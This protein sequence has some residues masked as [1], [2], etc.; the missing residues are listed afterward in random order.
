MNIEKKIQ[1]LHSL[2]WNRNPA[3]R[4]PRW[5]FEVS[6][7]SQAFSWLSI[8]GSQHS[9]FLDA[10]WLRLNTVD[11]DSQ[12]LCVQRNFWG[13]VGSVERAGCIGYF[14]GWWHDLFWGILCLCMERERW[15]VLHFIYHQKCQSA[16]WLYRGYEQSC[17][18]DTL[19][20]GHAE[21][22][23]QKTKGHVSILAK[24]H[25]VI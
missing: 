20:H 6:S 23:T 3:L 11:R 24:S 9:A 17:Q 7:C 13:R 5:I 22:G 12:C 21:S 19:N 1:I 2:G 25:S 15:T 8:H 16:C 4:L 14:L 18:V 10:Q